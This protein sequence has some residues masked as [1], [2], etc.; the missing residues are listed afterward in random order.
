MMKQP[1]SS[2]TLVVLTVLA[3]SM[4]ATQPLHAEVVEKT[5]KAAGRTVRYKVVL[6]HWV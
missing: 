5:T 3:A 6:P 4:F 2:R 1:S